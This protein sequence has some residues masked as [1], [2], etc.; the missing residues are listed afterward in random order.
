[1]TFRIGH[2]YDVHRL[3]DSG[4][5]VLGGVVVGQGLS[6]LAHSDG[7]VVCHAV[8]DA[9]LGAVAAGDIGE[10]FPDTDPSMAGIGGLELLARSVTIVRAVGF[11]PA[12]CDVTVLAE[13]PAVSPRRAEMRERLAAVLGVPVAAV[14]VKATRP[15]GLG[16]S[17][18]GIGCLTVATVEPID[19]D[20]PAQG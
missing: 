1:M 2:G 13:R 9:L 7:D 12:A 19:P 5:L 16:L 20:G 3:Q 15:E 18:D 14:S 8:A 11:V 6:A 4:Q 17:G 10:Q